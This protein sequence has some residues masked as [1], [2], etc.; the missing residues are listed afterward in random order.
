VAARVG[1]EL[2]YGLV[3]DVEGQY[4]AGESP[5][6]G[7]IAPGITWY[8]PFRFYAGVYY[9]RWLVGSGL[10][11]QNAVGARGGLTLLSAG[12]TFVGVGASYERALDCQGDCTSWWPEASVGV[13]F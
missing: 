11:D 3:L 7:K 4:W 8:A 5:Q 6:M 2:A 1:R 13:A 9:A 10:P 12:R